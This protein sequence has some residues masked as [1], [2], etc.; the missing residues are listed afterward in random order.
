MYEGILSRDYPVLMGIFTVV[1]FM[2][3]IANIITDIVY[4]FIDPRVV[5][6]QMTNTK[7][8]SNQLCPYDNPVDGSANLTPNGAAANYPQ[9]LT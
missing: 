4:A 8:I 2:V 6:K 3:I 7:I 9:P 5:Y 1:T